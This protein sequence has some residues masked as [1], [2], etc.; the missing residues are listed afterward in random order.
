M[1]PN[2]SKLKTQRNGVG[3]TDLQDELLFVVSSDGDTVQ[4][5]NL[6]DALSRSST[7]LRDVTPWQNIIANYGMHPYP[8]RPPDP[9]FK[10]TALPNGEQHTLRE[11][12]LHVMA[13]CHLI[14]PGVVDN[15]MPIIVSSMR[16]ALKT[17]NLE[18]YTW[19]ERNG[20][21][22]IVARHS[23]WRMHARLNAEYVGNVALQRKLYSRLDMPTLNGR[24]ILNHT[25]L[26][27]VHTNYEL[28]VLLLRGVAALR[29][30][31]VF[32]VDRWI[33]TLYET[34][35]KEVDSPMPIFQNMRAV[36]EIL[37]TEGFHP[38]SETKR[39]TLLL[40][41]VANDIE[42]MHWLHN[43]Y[44]IS[45]EQ[46][47]G[48]LEIADSRYLTPSWSVSEARDVLVNWDV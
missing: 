2:L 29:T 45:S 41:A 30:S 35:A 47:I 44:G 21:M 19:L 20:D 6:V 38:T 4:L 18:L 46:A 39:L 37:D 17:N 42:T 3:L 43:R 12:R 31:G 16:Q 26:A 5:C 23:E 24:M 8:S 9:P 13:Y 48:V 7:G 32:V 40:A 1:L 36:W 25:I 28:G 34:V 22:N 11:F 27:F 15:Y 33:D 14:K 10:G